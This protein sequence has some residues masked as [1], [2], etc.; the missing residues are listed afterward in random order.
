[1]DYSND[2]PGSV[3]G[4]LAGVD[5]IQEF[6]VITTNYTAE[7]GKT[8]GGVINAITQFGASL[9][10]PIRKDKSF[11]SFNYEGLRQSLST[12]LTSTVP[13]ANALAGVLSTGTVAVNPLV[14]PYLALWPAANG[15]IL[16][17]GD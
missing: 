3:L 4:N 13:S 7:Y 6:S 9:G 15:Q 8:S 2:G 17:T 11:A 12:T 10:G 14:K 16:G 5:A 1:N